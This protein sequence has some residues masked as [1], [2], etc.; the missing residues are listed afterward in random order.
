MSTVLPT[1]L[2]WRLFEA[3]DGGHGGHARAEQ[4]VGLLEQAGYAVRGIDRSQP[5]S[6]LDRVHGLL[7]KLVAP[8]RWQGISAALLGHHARALATACVGHAG[9]RLIICEDTMTPV[10]L[11]LAARHGFRVLALPQNVENLTGASTR[12]PAFRAEAAALRQ[13]D[14]VFCIS[15]EDAWLWNN[16]GITAGHLPYVP[17]GP[18]RQRLELIAEARRRHPPPSAAPWLLLGTVH[19]APTREGMRRIFDWMAPVLSERRVMVAGHGTETLAGAVP[20]GVELLG[21]V[22]DDVLDELRR[23]AQGLIVHQERGTGFLTRIPE[24]L[25]AGL[26][27][28]AHRHAAR[29]ATELAGVRVYADRTRF[30]ELLREPPPPVSMPPTQDAGSFLA[31]VRRLAS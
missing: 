1:L 5:G 10:P 22:T 18:R 4:I 25:C 29:S 23:E 31:A 26:P 2:A 20:A 27:V 16:L 6:P 7:H 14:A 13:A 21:S 9:P 11:W 30:L 17:L 15:A 8:R 28:I 12:W 24:A 3:Q 19:N